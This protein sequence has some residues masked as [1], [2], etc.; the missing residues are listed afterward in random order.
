MFKEKAKGVLLS[1]ILILASIVCFACKDKTKTIEVESISFNDSTIEMLVGESYTPGITVLPHDASERGYKLVSEDIA[2]V[3]VKGGT[4]TAL[5]EGRGIQLKVVSESNSLI[6]DM[7]SVDVYANPVNLQTPSDIVFD[8]TYFSFNAVDGASSYALKINGEE[9]NIGNNTEYAFANL[10]GKIDNLYDTE[11]EFS[12]KAIGDERIHI[13]SQY[14]ASKKIIKLSEITSAYVENEKLYIKALPYITSY[15]V[16]VFKSSAQVLTKSASEK[17]GEYYVLDIANLS[18]SVNGAEYNIK[19][20]A[21]WNGLIVGEAPVFG[22]NGIEINYAVLGQVKNVV[23]NN[24]VLTWDKVANADNYTIEIYNSTGIYTTYEDV[25]QNRIKVEAI[26]VAGEYYCKV[27]ANSETT[28]NVLTGKMY[29]TNVDFEVLSKPIITFNDGIIDWTDTGTEGYLLYIEDDNNVLVNEVLVSANTYDVSG[30]GAGEYLVKVASCGNGTTTLNSVYTDLSEWIV[31]NSVTDLSVKNKSVSWKD[32]DENSL[33]TYQLILKLGNDEKINQVLD[34][35]DV[36]YSEGKYNYQLPNSLGAG[37][38]KIEVV[39][40]GENNVFDS[41]KFTVDYTILAQPQ[42]LSMNNY[43]TSWTSVNKATSYTMN[44]YKQDNS[45]VKT[46]ESASPSQNVLNDIK[47]IG[48]DYSGAYYYNVVANIDGTLN[49]DSENL[50]SSNLVF[51]VLSPATIDCADG[52]V[53]WTHDN[54][55]ENITGYSIGVTNG[56]IRLPNQTLSKDTNS[57]TIAE[58][59]EKYK[60]LLQTMGVSSIPAG[61]YQISINVLGD[62]TT[63]LTSP[64]GTTDISLLNQVQNLKVESDNAIKLMWQDLDTNSLHNYTVTINVDEEINEIINL[65]ESDLGTKFTYDDNSKYYSLDLSSYNFSVGNHNIIITNCGNGA[66]IFDSKPKTITLVKPEDALITAINNKVLSINKHSQTTYEIKIY[67]ESDTTFA[68]PI[69][70]A[71]T[72]NTINAGELVAGKYIAR[73]YAYG[74]GGNV[75]DANNSETA[76]YEFE[77]LAVPEMSLTGNVITI[78][79]VDSASGYNLI[80]DGSASEYS[81]PYDVSTLTAGEY[82]YTCQAIGNNG[83]VLDSAISEISIKIKK[84]STPTLTFN[85]DGE[86]FTINCTDAS[87]VENYQFELSLGGEDILS[88]LLTE[89]TANC[90]G[91]LETAGEYEVSVTA[92]R[93]SSLEGFDLVLN[94]AVNNELVITKLSADSSISVEGRSLIITPSASLGNGSFTANVRIVK[95]ASEIN[96]TDFVYQNGKFTKPLY[97]TEYDIIGFDIDEFTRMFETTGDYTIYI[98]IAKDDIY[99]LNSAETQINNVTVINEVNTISFDNNQ[100]AFNSVDNANTYCMVATLSDTTKYIDITGE[101]TSTEDIN[102]ITIDT[103]KELMQVHGIDYQTETDYSVGFIGIP[104][105]GQGNVYIPNKCDTVTIFKFLN[106]PEVEIVEQ[107]LTESQNWDEILSIKDNVD[108]NVKYRVIFTQNGTSQ[109]I[110]ITTTDST[111]ALSQLINFNEGEINIAAQAVPIN[112]KTTT[113]AS[114]EITTLTINKLPTSEVSVN[115]GSLTWSAVQG[116]RQYKLFYA[117]TEG[118]LGSHNYIVLNEGDNNLAFASGQYIYDFQDLDA[119]LYK[120]YIQVD[121]VLD[122]SYCINSNYS[123]PLENVRKLTKAIIGVENGV[124]K[125]EFDKEATTKTS[126]FEIKLDN[127]PIDLIIYQPS[128]DVRVQDLGTKYISYI[129]PTALLKYNSNKASTELTAENLKI[130]LKAITDGKTLDS[131]IDSK[132]LY[133]LLKPENLTIKTSTDATGSKQIVEKISWENPTA[134]GNYVYNYI[135][136]ITYTYTITNEETGEIQ[137]I[138]EDCRFTSSTTS[139]LMPTYYDKD[140]SGDLSDGDVEFK[141]GD[142]QIYVIA[143]S[144]DNDCIVYSHAT[145]PINISILPA[146]T[147]LSVNSGDIVWSANLDAERY[148][149]RVYNMSSQNHELVA[150]TITN[151][152]IYDLTQLDLGDT[153]MIYGVTIQA[154]HSSPNVLVSEEGEMVEMIRLPQAKGYYVKDGILYVR[155]HKFF[156]T[157]RLTVGNRTLTIS[158]NAENLRG[159]LEDFVMDNINIFDMEGSIRRAIINSYADDSYYIDVPYVYSTDQVT[160]DKN[161]DLRTVNAGEYSLDIKLYGNSSVIAVD[162]L[163]IKWGMISG[164]TLTDAPNL[165]AEQDVIRKLE[166]P[167]INISSSV[168]GRVELSMPVGVTYSALEYFKNGENALKGI[169]LYKINITTNTDYT[170]YVAQ[171]VDNDLFKQSATLLTGNNDLKYFAYNGI[172]YNVL[173][174]LY[175]DFNNSHYYYYNSQGQPSNIELSKGGTITVSAKLLGDDTYYVSSNDTV[176]LELER[177]DSLSLMVDNGGLKWEAK[178]TENNV[179]MLELTNNN[180]TY[181]VVLYNPMTHGDVP[182]I[183]GADRYIYD[184][185]YSIITEIVVDAVTGQNRE[186][187]YVV[188]DNLANTLFNINGINTTSTISFESLVK[189][190]YINETDLGVLLA[191][192]NPSAT[193]TVLGQ[194]NV[195]INN[196]ELTWS[197][198]YINEG[199][200]TKP[201]TDYKLTIYNVDTE[202]SY[203]I[204]LD[205]SQYTTSGDTIT[206]KLQPSY[207]MP[208]ES[209]FEISS[210]YTYEFSVMSLALGSTSY[211]N[212]MFGKTDEIEVLA[213]VTGLNMRNGVLQWNNSNGGKVEVRVSFN[214]GE[215]QVVYS[216]IE[217]ITS[218][219]LPRTSVTDITGTTIKFDS[220]DAE[221][222]FYNYSVSIRVIGNSSALSSFYTSISNLNRLPNMDESTIRTEDGVLKWDYADSLGATFTLEYELDDGTTGVANN[223]GKSFDFR[224]LVSEHIQFKLTAKSND[225]FQSFTAPIN[226][227]NN[228]TVY[229]LNAPNDIKYNNNDKTITWTAITDNQGNAIAGYNIKVV[230]SNGEHSYFTA[231]NSWNIANG[232]DSEFD[233]FIQS[234]AST[235]NIMTV[236]SEFSDELTLTRPNAVDVT[237]FKYNQDKLRFELKAIDGEQNSDK[238]YISY[239]YYPVGE[240]Y[241]QSK[242]IEVIDS[243]VVQGQKYYYYYPTAIGEYRNVYIQVVRAGGI[244]SEAIG[245][246]DDEGNLFELNFNWFANGDGGDEDPYQISNETELRNISKFLS[247]HYVITSQ[248]TLRSVEPITNKSQVFSGHITGRSDCGISFNSLKVDITGSGGYVG[249]FATTNGAIF[250]NIYLSGFNIDGY[251]DGV[252][253][254]IGCLVAYAENTTF[255]NI[256]LSA[257]KINVIKDNINSISSNT[258][259]VYIGGVVGYTKG[260]TVSNCRIQLT[261]SEQSSTLQDITLN[262]N[263]NMNTI[264]Y[265]GGIIGYATGGSCENNEVYYVAKYTLSGNSGTPIAYTGR[266]IGG[267]NTISTQPETNGNSGECITIINSSSSEITKDIGNS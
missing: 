9:I 124:V 225:M 146:P 97:N 106:Q 234:V 59:E 90:L 134:N 51:N 230:D 219:D 261:E 211:V 144:N 3:G 61:D 64:V 7:I 203:S 189:L 56:M 112:S 214:T 196:G 96:I 24:Y 12:V 58:F 81:A 208:D 227:N 15:S 102:I 266:C 240:N 180:I 130:R 75:L 1:F 142:Y 241:P 200:T 182:S 166:T 199:A 14:S 79:A 105:N 108:D 73:I 216:T 250:K 213:Q 238:Y 13:S 21:N 32:L 88:T 235:D 103:I 47:N 156:T 69:E 239:Q 248:I 68:S 45:L 163:N 157:A 194:P 173:T 37:D 29:S 232:I 28:Q 85:K 41:A 149:I 177:Y 262:I 27:I 109:E 264:L 246:Y 160:G 117:N 221:G 70:N 100:I 212:S 72:G 83:D 52:S 128:D 84:L 145:A 23:M 66:E 171:I 17:I 18:D 172:Y 198:V 247:A 107:E 40:L 257:S 6:N 195:A 57:Y 154:L 87:V 192:G 123:T 259:Q 153:P 176:K 86:T 152:T 162:L 133:G 115:N 161:Y 252:T 175:F 121:S 5:K 113:H 116:A 215:K 77:K 224:G 202:E 93:T 71:I 222:D 125:I 183:L 98:T 148:F 4:I 170:L 92:T 167:I 126:S 53:S 188:Y 179:Y 168:R 255:D 114:S 76:I 44:L 78:S 119:G 49:V 205:S 38:Y 137:E 95:G 229:K 193:V 25:E 210:D 209:L 178:A 141:A 263:G 131:S 207:P 94:S 91:E 155:I 190:Y 151:N 10:E 55:V 39:S 191:Q 118:E 242:R 165:N 127:E 110:E 104:S 265:V 111:Y 46:Y 249:L 245:C 147:N 220:Q 169:N 185:N 89:T 226:M 19:I 54:N 233:I 256:N 204:N 244:A 129:N 30:Y 60:L 158:N 136:V 2:L 65:T 253:T 74:N 42:N 217:T 33:N 140:E 260:C 120:F 181:T 67:A 174:N 187:Q 8:G 132:D 99:V 11:L 82:T 218:F 80:Q 143:N 184:T 197:K 243:Q 254:Y 236:N 50:V 36:T 16:Q 43:L 164:H 101:Y 267:Y 186:V 159:Y 122:D 139:L 22:G 201:V 206:Y 135:V 31:L 150:S 20:K 138:T 63:Y 48:E 34:I 62:N 228:L 231:T 26:D 251:L 237:T 35:D 258:I 223:L